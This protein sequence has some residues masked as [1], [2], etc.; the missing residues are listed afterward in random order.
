MAAAASS[1]WKPGM[2][3]AHVPENVLARFRVANV[4]PGWDPAWMEELLAKT[5]ETLRTIALIKVFGPPPTPE[6]LDPY[7]LT[8]LLQEMLFELVSEK[9]QQGEGG[10]AASGRAEGG[11]RGASSP[12]IGEGVGSSAA[13]AAATSAAVAAAGAGASL[14]GD[15]DDGYDDYD[16]DDDDDDDDSLAVSYQTPQAGNLRF[17]MYASTFRAMVREKMLTQEEAQTMIDILYS[18]CREDP[19][20]FLCLKMQQLWKAKGTK[21][22]QVVAKKIKNKGWRKRGEFTWRM[23]QQLRAVGYGDLW[24]HVGAEMN[25]VM[26]LE[27]KAEG[28]LRTLAFKA[29]KQEEDKE[30]RRGR[31]GRR[32]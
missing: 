4:V 9:L 5:E 32:G 1:I 6:T 2:L 30:K 27:I 10:V 14:E 23:Y 15:G 18:E 19:D 17:I 21:G 25:Y 24:Q 8:L 13:A 26:N 28:C 3:K 12:E 11:G 31:G 7:R 20:H 16:D 29:E 22:R